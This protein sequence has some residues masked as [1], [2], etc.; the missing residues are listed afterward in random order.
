VLGVI[1]ALVLAALSVQ[2]SEIVG[3]SAG[4]SANPRRAVP[5][6]VRA[7]FIR[8]VLIYICSGKVKCNS[9]MFIPDT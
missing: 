1:N 3:I 2:G 7:V 6:A 8:I 5:S 4:E 9:F